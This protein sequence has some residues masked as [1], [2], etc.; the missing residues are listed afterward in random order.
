MV[1]GPIEEGCQLLV[2]AIFR[3]AVCDLIGVSYNHEATRSRRIRRRD[4]SQEA[5]LFLRSHWARELGELAC[6][7]VDEVVANSLRLSRRSC[8][9]APPLTS[10]GTTDQL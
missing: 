5:L 9:A 2:V 10:S 8:A 3:L 1:A 6:I 4:D 7:P